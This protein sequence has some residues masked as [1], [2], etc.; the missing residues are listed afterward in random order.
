MTRPAVDAS[1]RVSPQL[2]ALM[3]SRANDPDTDYPAT[4]AQVRDF[5]ADMLPGP[6]KAAE[7]MHRFDI[8]DSML[9][10]LD[11]LIEEYGRDALAADFCR[12]SASEPLSRVIEVV[13]NDEN[14][15]FP[16]TLSAV[17]DAMTSGLLTRLVGEGVLD[18]DEDDSL[19][20]EIE[21]LIDHHGADELAEG[22]LRYE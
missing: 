20:A 19:L 21:A 3:E 8:G 11:A 13:I 4:L 7:R 10:E 6:F 15:E 17:R 14:R 12:V 5:L 18:G 2:S 9:D 1:I 16:P 22:F